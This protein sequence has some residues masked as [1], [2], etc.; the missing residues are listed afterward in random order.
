MGAKTEK[1]EKRET[2]KLGNGG[3]QK[4]DMQNAET[5]EKARLKGMGKRLVK[6]RSIQVLVV[7]S[8]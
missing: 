1:K 7:C 8:R 3:G 5:A 2:K 4:P 6:K